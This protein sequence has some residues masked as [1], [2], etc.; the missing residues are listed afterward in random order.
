MKRQTLVSFVTFVVVQWFTVTSGFEIDVQ[1][2]MREYWKMPE[3]FQYESIEACFR[4]NPAGVFCVVK[5]VVKPDGRS[6]IWRTIEKYSRYSFQHQH[7][8]LTRGIC[9]EQCEELVRMLS[10]QEKTQFLQPKFDVPYKYIVN[11]WMVPNIHNYRHQYGTIVNIC[12]NY[13]IQTKYNIS[14]YS[15][16]EYCTT[17]ST[18]KTDYLDIVFYA[19]ILLLL[20]FALASTIYDSRHAKDPNHYRMPL[21]GKKTKLLTAFSLRR[22]INRLTFK[23]KT[24]PIQQDLCFLDTIR[25]YVT[26]IIAFSHVIIGLGVTPSQNPEAMEKYLSNAGVQML[27]ALMPFEVDVF[28]AISG[29]LLTVHFIKYTEGKR[30]SIKPFWM[31]VVNRFIRSLPVYAL[32]ILF[33]TSIFDR[34]QISPSAYTV[35]PIIRTICRDKWWTNLLFINNYYRPGEQC[36]IHTWYLAADIQ[37]FIVGLMILMVLW[38][39]NSLLRPIIYFLLVVGIALPMANVY[40]NSMDAMMLVNLKESAFVMWYDEWF[41][42]TYQATETHCLCY[43]GGMLVGIIYHKMQNDNLLLAKSRL[44]RIL[45]YITVPMLVLFC[46]SAPLFLLFNYSKPSMWM[47]LYAGVHRLVVTCFVNVGFLLLMFAQP[48]SFFGKL[49]MSNVLQNAFYRV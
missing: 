13:R 2:N 30:F 48:G 15:E 46:L 28:F 38:K 31:G 32:V 49:R 10:D 41:T 11:D 45:Q 27:L 44:Y 19:T 36:L 9:L 22:N 47:S 42:R 8:V 12:Q 7:S 4:S 5:S 39:C 21:K 29:L 23:P 34:L 33:S 24:D 43:F 3:L 35:V 17:N 1:F 14:V 25:V 6:L 37:L 20:L 26:T 40:Y 18:R 16:L